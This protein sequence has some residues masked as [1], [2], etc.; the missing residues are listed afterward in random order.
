M[1]W[2]KASKNLNL[3]FLFV[4]VAIGLVY[5]LTSGGD[6]PY[7]YSIRLSEA[8]LNGRYWIEENPPWLSELIP[9]G[10]N[11]FYMVYPPMPAIMAFP[12]VLIFGA[13]FPQQLLAHLIGIGIVFMTMKISYLMTNDKWIS[14]WAAL[15]VGIGSIVWFLASVG[16]VWYIGQISACFWLLCAIY[17]SLHKKRPLLVGLLLGAAYLSRVHVIISLPFFVYL[18]FENRKKNISWNSLRIIIL[19][20]VGMLPYLLFNFWYNFVRFGSIFDKG[21]FI[22]PGILNELNAPWFKYGL[23]NIIYMPE[24]L[25]TIFWSF[26]KISN[27]FPYVIPSWNGLA[28][29]ITSPFFIYALFASVRNGKNIFAWISILS[30]FMIVGSHGGN[31]FA[32]FGYRFAVDFY[33]FLI[34]LT[35]Q[36]VHRSKFRIH[37]LLLL[38]AIVVNMWG[39]I[40]INK[41]GWVMF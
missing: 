39:V 37:W 10:Q 3:L 24:H 41:F 7:N 22:L 29:W 40:W 1:V 31:G 36:G 25:R 9:A 8:F 16:S 30:I 35:I 5:L 19:T 2:S 26:P 6:T 21:Y 17:E 23:I 18:L 28:I 4:S 11:R 12:F 14:I 27:V 20:C 13:S 34:F 38:L 15:A 32:Q 33:P